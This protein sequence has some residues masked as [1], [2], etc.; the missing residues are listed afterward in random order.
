MQEEAGVK[1]QVIADYLEHNLRSA[2][3]S[4]KSRAA[5]KLKAGESEDAPTVGSS[6]GAFRKF[7]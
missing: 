4:E 5:A 6:F 7:K 3:E 1:A 2:Y